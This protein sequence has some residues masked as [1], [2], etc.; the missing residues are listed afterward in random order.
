MRFRHHRDHR[1]TIIYFDVTYL[2][3]N[4][5]STKIPTEIR[6]CCSTLYVKI[7]DIVLIFLYDVK[8]PISEMIKTLRNECRIFLL[9]Y[10]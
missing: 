8:N 7:N 10:K 9:S 5:K 1:V 4:T 3:L 6:R 2:H